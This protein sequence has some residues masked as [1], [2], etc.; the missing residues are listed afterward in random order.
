MILRHAYL[1]EGCKARPGTKIKQVES[2][3]I[4]W[5]GA[6]PGQ[7][8]EDTRHWWI[9]SGGDAGAHFIVKDELVLATIPI[10]EVAY[11]CG[12]PMGNASSI[13]IEVIPFDKEGAFSSTSIMTLKELIAMMPAVPLKR[14]YDWSGK[15][16]PLYYTPLA[17]DGDV[18]W[19][20]LRKEIQKVILRRFPNFSSFPPVDE[21]D[22]TLIYYDT[23]D[24][25]EYYI[26][27]GV[28][29][30]RPTSNET[31]QPPIIGNG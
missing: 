26:T 21:A 29:T 8:P 14:H 28:Y 6:F 19:A 10:D 17:F 24:D 13:G 9:Q 15:N 5:I 20:A 12:V 11:H 22:D 18:H 25:Q 7:V 27:G 31:P 30:K 4:H 1:P 23:A 3:T 16:C 2:I